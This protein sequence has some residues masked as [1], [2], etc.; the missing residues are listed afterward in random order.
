[1]KTALALVA[2]LVTTSIASAEPELKGS[3]AELTQYLANMPHLVALTGE[4]ELKVPADRAVI[5]LKVV[6]ENKLLQ[7][8]SRLNQEM[9]AKMLKALTDRGVPAERVQ[10]SKFSSTP[11]YGIFGDKAKSYRVENVV[12]IKAQDEKEFQAITGLVD[13][14]PE[15]RYEGVEFEHSDKDSLK[16][17]ALT[18]AIEKAAE[19]KRMYEEKLGVTLSVKG[20]SEGGVAAVPLQ[21]RNRYQNLPTASA[22]YGKRTETLI[23]GVGAVEGDAEE[24]PTSFG[25]LAFI[26]RVTVEY[27]VEAK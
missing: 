3:A 25:E 6:T 19:K 20:F 12:K 23:S 10:P 18:Q 8:A 27:A 16:K 24:A 26:G 1:M 4:A 13:G 7:E 15:V 2:V 14:W 22:T 17:N 9:R 21:L 5:S 11:K